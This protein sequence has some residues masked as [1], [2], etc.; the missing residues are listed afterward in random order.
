MNLLE[1][2]SNFFSW[3]SGVFTDFVNSI[4]SAVDGLKLAYEQLLALDNKIVAAIDS[5]FSSE[6]GRLPVVDAIGNVRF[7]IGDTI[8]YIIYIFVLFGCLFTIIKIVTLIYQSITSFKNIVKR[9]NS[10][11]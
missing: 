9:T 6:F 4:L 2:F 11:Y 10:W 8:F 5:N 3:L 1:N 7:L